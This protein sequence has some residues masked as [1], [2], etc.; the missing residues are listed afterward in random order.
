MHEIGPCPDCQ[1]TRCVDFGFSVIILEPHF[2]VLLRP[3]PL[4]RSASSSPSGLATSP[5]LAVDLGQTYSSVPRK[6]WLKSIG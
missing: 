1:L 4:G 5:N 6:E 3:E 2:A